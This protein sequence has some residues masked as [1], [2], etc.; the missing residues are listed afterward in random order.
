MNGSSYIF[1]EHTMRKANVIGYDSDM[2]RK[3]MPIDTI[4]TAAL[5]TFK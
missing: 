5:D 4:V 3:R 1:L 2:V